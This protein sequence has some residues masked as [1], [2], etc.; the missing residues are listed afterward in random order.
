MPSIHTYPD[1]IPRF[2]DNI[3]SGDNAT[4]ELFIS[5]SRMTEIE[6]RKIFRQTQDVYFSALSVLEKNNNIEYIQKLKAYFS[7]DP[8]QKICLSISNYVL[9]RNLN[10]SEIALKT[11]QRETI[12]IFAKAKRTCKDKL[13]SIIIEIDEMKKRGDKWQDI[14]YVLKTGTHRK[15]FSNETLN[16]R[17]VRKV[18]A[19]WK[20][21]K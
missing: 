19:N 15:M 14:I 5:F 17:N 10:N 2:V 13:L 7:K 1:E 20:N 16:E 4:H 6:Q 21:A 9:H 12:K 18:Y 11:N 3:I 8:Y